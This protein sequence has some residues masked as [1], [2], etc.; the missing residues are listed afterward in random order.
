MIINFAEIKKILQESTSRV[1]ITFKLTKALIIDELLDTEALEKV[2][3]NLILIRKQV[4]TKYDELELTVDDDFEKLLFVQNKSF[5]DEQI[6]MLLRNI[7]LN[8]NLNKDKSTPEYQ[9]KLKLS[10]IVIKD[11]HDTKVFYE[12]LS[13]NLETMLRLGFK[14]LLIERYINNPVAEE[15]LVKDLEEDKVESVF[16]ESNKSL[17]QSL[18]AYNKVRAEHLKDFCS[19]PMSFLKSLATLEDDAVDPRDIDLESHVDHYRNDLY[20]QAIQAGISVVNVDIY[21]Q[22]DGSNTEKCKASM[23]LRRLRDFGFS[24]FLAC[25]PDSVMIVGAAH[26]PG[27]DLLYRQIMGARARITFICADYRYLTPEDTIHTHLSRHNDKLTSEIYRLESDYAI[28]MSASQTIKARD[29]FLSILRMSASPDKG[30]L[31][32]SASSL[33]PCV[34]QGMHLSRSDETEDLRLQGVEQEQ[35]GYRVKF[36][37]V[38][39]EGFTSS[40]EFINYSVGGCDELLPHNLVQILAM[41]ERSHNIST[42]DLRSYN[43]DINILARQSGKTIQLPI[44]LKD[45]KLTIPNQMLNLI[46]DSSARPSIADLQEVDEFL[47]G[48]NVV[49]TSS[50]KVGGGAPKHEVLESRH[51]PKPN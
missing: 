49:K 9:E 48:A 23:E 12:L 40:E 1:E 24:L 45:G 21:D 35:T 37:C 30:Y 28:D 33:K 51:N 29:D 6:A 47:G 39:S 7:D 41:L 15:T 13:P 10:P 2:R 20:L 4:G 36:D 25:N 42:S 38:N 46:K 27:I 26:S 8:L 17:S 50:D 43:L 18:G 3:D 19:N 5:I 32:L 14:N 11:I 16:I 34:R 22:R 44:S 31:T